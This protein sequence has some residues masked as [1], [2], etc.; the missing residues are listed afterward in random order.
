MRTSRRTSG[1]S[2]IGWTPRS[3]R[4]ASRRVS[5]RQKEARC[6]SVSGRSRGPRRPSSFI[7][8]PMASPSTRRAGSKTIRTRPCS[9]PRAAP[10]VPSRKSLGIGSTVLARAIG[11]IGGSLRARLPIRRGRT[12]SFSRRSTRCGRRVWSPRS[13]SKSSSI[14][15]RRWARRTFRRRSRST[16]IYLRPI[17]SSFS[18]GLR[19]FRGG[20]L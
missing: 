5:C 8:S 10:A 9:R 4:V 20:L 18:T 1:R 14:P 16:G 19:I 7:F 13:I 2:S 3:R 15:K 12:C 11:G 17:C 6:S